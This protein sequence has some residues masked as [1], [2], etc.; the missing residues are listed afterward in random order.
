MCILRVTVLQEDNKY[1]VNN[2][3]N[4]VEYSEST[5]SHKNVSSKN[6]APSLFVNLGGKK[7]KQLTCKGR[8]TLHKA[9]I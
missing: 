2:R 1:A 5:E 8:K 3:A 4:T 9:S 7:E 6:L